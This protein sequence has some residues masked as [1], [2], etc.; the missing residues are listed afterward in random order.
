MILERARITVRAEQHSIQKLEKFFADWRGLQKHKTRPTAGHRVKEYE[1]MQRFNDLFDIAHA[2]AL[3]LI[4]IP[5]DKAFLVAQREKGRP[6]SMAS[7]DMVHSRREQRVQK[8]SE[9]EYERFQ[10]SQVDIETSTSQ[11]APDSDSS[12]VSSTAEE[13]EDFVPP[14]ASGSGS[15]IPK[16]AR[17]NIMSPRCHLLSTNQYLIKKCN[18]YCQ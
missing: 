3:T 10:R 5:E 11:A 8:R 13:I 18:L 15:P 9:A 4:T 14:S 7:V 1:F 2:D 17:L 6:G 16:R 12:S